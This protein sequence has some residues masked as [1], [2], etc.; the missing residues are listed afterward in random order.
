MFSM[1]VFA[2]FYG[3]TRYCLV[4]YSGAQLEQAVKNQTSWGTMLHT[5]P[6]LQR[7]GL[8][9]ARH[10][11]SLTVDFQFER[12]EAAGDGKENGTRAYRGKD[13]AGQHCPFS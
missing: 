9:P 2:G 13:A 12:L 10:S 11:P 6:S 7:N 8:L 1:I 4:L 5:Q 3:L